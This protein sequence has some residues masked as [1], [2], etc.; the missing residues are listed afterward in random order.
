M[1]KKLY[2]KMRGIIAPPFVGQEEV[3]RRKK[4]ITFLGIVLLSASSVLIISTIFRREYPALLSVLLVDVFLLGCIILARNG[5]VVVASYTLPIALCITTTFIAFKG[6]GIHDIALLSFPMII[7]LGGLMQGKQGALLTALQGTICFMLIYW[8]EI[9]HFIPDAVQ[10]RAYTTFDDIFVMMILLW[11]TAAFI[12]FAMN[13][14]THSIISMQDG[15]QALRQANENLEKYTSTLEQRTQQLLTGAKVSRAASTILDPDELCQQVVDMVGSRFDLYFASLYLTD[16]EGVWA[17]LHAGTGKAGKILLKGGHKLRI[18]NTSMI[19]WCIENQ[20]A[21]IALDVG[22]EAVRFNNPLLSE[23]RSELALPL[24]SRGQII[25]ALG[26]QSKEEAAFSEEEIAI[27][28]AMADQ[29][30]N[31]ISNARLYHQLQRELTERKRVEKKIRKLNIELESRVAERTRELQI[32][33]ENL[34]TLGHLKDQFLA[35]VSHELRTPL[36]SIKLY[37]S[38]IEKQP[39]DAGLYILHL[40]RETDRLARLIEDLLYLS[41]LDQ[42]YAPFQ[43][44]PLDLNILAQQYFIDRSPLAAERKLELAFEQNIDLPLAYADEQMTGQVMSAILTNAINYTPPGGRII[45]ATSTK[46]IEKQSWTG[47]SISDTGLGISAEDRE[48]L[49]ER[50]HRGTVGRGSTTPGTGLGLSIVKEIINRHNGRIEVQSE[51]L[52]GKGTTF[53]IWLPIVEK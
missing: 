11:I 41:R 34:T 37:H 3:E 5:K 52:P 45:I 15:E 24:I 27:Y 28:Q 4:T 13:N 23:T 53:F 8:G 18:G 10:F 32:A 19:G 20:K 48:H 31:A 12:Y 50:F 21:R 36:T 2:L 17:V 46:K 29:L 51:G 1:L 42:G 14:L 35:N 22:K 7:A 44:V 38:L 30:A 49:F 39:R 26:I 6:Q 16:E 40:K 25:G 47:F 43:P 9:N 33:N